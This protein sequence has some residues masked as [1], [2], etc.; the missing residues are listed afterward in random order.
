MKLVQYIKLAR[1]D[2]PIGIY[3]LL[4]PS[5]MG[6]LIG[7]I[8]ANLTFKSFLIVLCGAIIVRSCGCVINDISDHNIDKSVKRTQTRPLAA[9][10]LTIF[11]AWTFFA[12]LALFSLAILL[13]TPKLTQMI[14]L[15]FAVCIVIYPLTK[16]FLN[17]PQVF[18][19]ITF[20][21]GAIISYSLV[22]SDFSISILLLYIAVICWTIS[23]DTFYAMEDLKDDLKIG[24]NSTAILWKD[25][26]I[27]VALFFHYV[28]LGIFT[29]IGL[30][31]E[32]S[33][34]F[35]FFV[36]LLVIFVFIQIGYIKKKKYLEAFKFNNWVGMICVLALSSEIIW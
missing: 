31:N 29:I 16:R 28:F 33:I 9:G 8:N 34:A 24:I 35:Y 19:G 14:S 27:K 20:G 25:N 2:K 22:N 30:L 15:I 13:I 11:E 10:K 7:G 5:L 1:L 36:L 12:I 23:F 3:L 18:L 4:W 32:F 17:A 26:A 21:S 6:L